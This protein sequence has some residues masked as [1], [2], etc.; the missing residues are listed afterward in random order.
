MTYQAKVCHWIHDNGIQWWPGRGG[1]G[2]GGGGG[3]APTHL[4]LYEV[5]RQGHRRAPGGRRSDF[6]QLHHQCIIQS[7]DLMVIK[8]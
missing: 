4:P 5:G 1:G 6:T 2:G 7:S 8:L 3:G